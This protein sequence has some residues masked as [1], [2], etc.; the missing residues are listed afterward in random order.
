MNKTTTSNSHIAYFKDSTGIFLSPIVV[1]A[2]ER[3]K[4]KIFDK[5]TVWL[6]IEIELYDVLDNDINTTQSL[7]KHLQRNETFNIELKMLDSSGNFIETWK[8]HKA[9][10]EYIEFGKLDWR[11]KDEL[12][13][14]KIK[15][16][17]E[18]AELVL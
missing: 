1:Y 5:K 17:Y 13:I 10:I 14:I 4:L 7:Y 6:P 18:Y 2:I 8:I 15:V 12:L 3:P 9:K 16:D 11:L